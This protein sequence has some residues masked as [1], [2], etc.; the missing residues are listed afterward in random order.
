MISGRRD[1]CFWIKRLRSIRIFS[2]MTPGSAFSSALEE[3][4]VWVMTFL[5]SPRMAASAPTKPRVTTSGARSTLPVSLLIVRIGRTMPSSLRLRRS[6]MTRSPTTS[7]VEPE[8]M[9]TRPAVT[10]PALRALVRVSSRIS[11]SS[12]R[13][14]SPMTP[15]DFASSVCFFRWRKS[16]WTGMKNLGRRRLMSRRCSSCEA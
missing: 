1:V 12:I 11:P 5:A 6:R 16:P 8:S 4:R 9:Q 14:A 2:F 10:L 15:V 7:A 13:I 3:S